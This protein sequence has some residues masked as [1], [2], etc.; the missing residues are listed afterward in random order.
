MVDNE[1]HIDLKA[2]DPNYTAVPE[3]VY[4]LKVLKLTGSKTGAGKPFVAGTFSITRNDKY[5]GRRIF[6]NFWN[7]A[8][9]NSRDAKDLRKLSDVTGVQQSGSFS[10]WLEAMT[11]EQPEFK[12][13]VTH[14]VK[15]EKTGE[16]D[17][18]TGKAVYKNQENAD[19]TPVVD[20]SINFRN[21]EI[22]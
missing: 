16:V 20:N 6:Y 7:A 17:P 8:D 10:Q 9:Q 15:Q 5:S 1:I 12:V 13:P 19:G 2:V 21:C 3:D 14:K 18:S 11:Q 22:A 4:V